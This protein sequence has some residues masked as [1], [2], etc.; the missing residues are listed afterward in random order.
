MT[1]TTDLFGRI[2]FL[3][4]IVGV[5]AGCEN[6]RP[7]YEVENRPIPEFSPALTLTQIEDG[8]VKAGRL[9]YWRLRPIESGRMEGTLSF[10]SRSAVVAINYDQRFFSIRYKSSHR[11]YAGKAW[12]DQAFEGQFVIHRRYNGHVRRLERAIVRELST[13]RS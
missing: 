8:I 1:F 12:P 5:A 2:F 10:G 13:P 9:R 7:I 4:L 6:V 11:L 3:F